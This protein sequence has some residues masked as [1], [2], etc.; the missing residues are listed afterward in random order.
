MPDDREVKAP[1]YASAG[2]SEY[3]VVDL[4]ADRV[5]V[6]RQPRGSSYQEVSTHPRG[7]VLRPTSFPELDVPV[8]V[9]LP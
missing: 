7:A 9:M 2:I 8:D 4:P 1:L 5:E 3:W 6:Y